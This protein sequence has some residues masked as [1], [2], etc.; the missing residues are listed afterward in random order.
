[1]NTT[2][3]CRLHPCVVQRNLSVESLPIRRY[4]PSVPATVLEELLAR[5]VVHLE[6]RWIRDTNH[7]AAEQPCAASRQDNRVAEATISNSS[8]KRDLRQRGDDESTSE[9]AHVQLAK[10]YL[11]FLEQNVQ[12]KL[13]EADN[14]RSASDKKM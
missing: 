3:V 11:R 7:T 1:M 14:K 5:L 2:T 13:R 8:L 4:R 12:R 6:R 10:H 9:H